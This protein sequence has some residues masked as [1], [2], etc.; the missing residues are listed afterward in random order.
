V[1]AASPDKVRRCIDRGLAHYGGGELRQAIG[2][3]Q[4]AL[5]LDPSNQEAHTLIE[6]VERKLA[7][8]Q[9]DG[10]DDDK[11][12]TAA[13]MPVPPLDDWGGRDDTEPNPTREIFFEI[14]EPVDEEAATG[15]HEMRHLTVESPIP[16]LLAP[17][18]SPGWKPPADRDEAAP[19]L[20]LADEETRR[21]GSERRAIPA[22]R[23]TLS[24]EAPSD[25]SVDDVRAR[26]VELVAK[27][28]GH[29]ERGNLEAAA[30][31]AEAALDEA[32]H[33][34]LPGVPEV[35]APA[36]RALFERAFEGYVGPPQ[37]V[38]AFAMSAGAL[39]GQE[40]DHRAGFLLSL[41]DGVMSIEALLDI[42]SMPR[43]EA[44]RILAALI[45]VGAIRVEHPR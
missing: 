2:Q 29:L 4:E 27:C 8:E 38:P 42:S 41:I 40:L 6:F 39:T 44:L 37:G 21:V 11:R 45:R 34:P 28:H 16:E 33:A 15:L 24:P 20:E 22:I 43:F 23:S 9:A 1:P 31:A 26:I 17:I 19:Q 14:L 32:E 13:A 36:A 30:V 3:W 25:D 7:G 12:T 18:T 5:V 35:M 10:I